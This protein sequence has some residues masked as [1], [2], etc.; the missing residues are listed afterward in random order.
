MSVALFFLTWVAFL[1][2]EFVVTKFP[3]WGTREKR[4]RLSSIVIFGL[5]ALGLGIVGVSLA[6]AFPALARGSQAEPIWYYQFVLGS[7]NI[8][9]INIIGL[10]LAWGAFPVRHAAKR[11]LG[12]FYT[13][14][15]AI[16]QDHQLI[17]SGIYRYVRHPLSLGILM[18]Y[19][20]LPLIISSILGLLIVTVPA[21]IGSF[22]RIRLEERTL[23][24]RFGEHYLAYAERTARLIPY[25]W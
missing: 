12:K 25:I 2:T 24:S 10:A 1:V 21:I 7:V 5:P 6:F 15:V 9:V 14:N 11:A 19:L 17:D 3:P 20:G 23:I 16:L 18:F 13:I 22:Y 4:D 8:G